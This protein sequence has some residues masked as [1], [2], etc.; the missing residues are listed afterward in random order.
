MFLFAHYSSMSW[1]GDKDVKDG[2]ITC[3]LQK[4]LIERFWK[5]LWKT[6]AM[7]CLF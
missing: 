6:P 7:D 4:K 3:V 2:T 1:G 5:T